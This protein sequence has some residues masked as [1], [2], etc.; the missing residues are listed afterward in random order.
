MRLDLYVVTDRKQA[1]GRSHHEV[2]EMA[3]AGGAD[4]IQLRDK[5]MDDRGL[6]AL[7]SD[8]RELTARM[9][10]LLI[11][12]DRPDIALASNADG[13][14]LGQ[15]DM[16]VAAVRRIL[17]P[18]MIVGASVGT[19]SEAVR[20]EEEG[21]SYVALSPVF[22]TG[23]KDDAGPGR[24][25]EMLSRMKDAVS[26]PVVAIGGID[27]SNAAS[28]IEAGADGIAVISAVVSQ[29]DIEASAR[30]LRQIVAEAKR[31]AGRS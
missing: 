23:S 29:D 14:H 11:V 28:V 2:V 10:A 8:L 13:V 22:S 18:S 7:A 6:L 25:L 3:L 26:I 21:A 12:N 31:R 9:G 17:P 5:D 15:D 27:G 4:V 16:P 24:G 19:V 30:S 1:K 20:A